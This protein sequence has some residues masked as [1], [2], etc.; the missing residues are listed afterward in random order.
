[1][2][3]RVQNTGSVI[4]WRVGGAGW[5]GDLGWGEWG[6]RGSTI[7]YKHER[8]I[9]KSKQQVVETNQILFICP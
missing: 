8:Q 1:M 2:E 6:V 7:I 4:N 3:V 5:W 9:E